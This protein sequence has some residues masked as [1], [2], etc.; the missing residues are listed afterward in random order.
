[1]KFA[2]SLSLCFRLRLRLRTGGV[3]EAPFPRRDELV[4]TYSTLTF[5][6]P[7]KPYFF[8]SVYFSVS[9]VVFIT[10][11]SNSIFR[12]SENVKMLARKFARL[13]ETRYVV[14]LHDYL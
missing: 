13:L 4:R 9:H 11:A 3:D 8:V 2:F 1:L 14:N 5:R 10:Q 12:K 6:S 7:L